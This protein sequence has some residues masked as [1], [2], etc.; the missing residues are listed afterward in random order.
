MIRRSVLKAALYKCSRSLTFNM[1][2]EYD[3][4][5]PRDKPAPEIS[6]YGFSKSSSKQYQEHND[7][8][9]EETSKIE[10]QTTSS[11]LKII[12]GLFTIIVSLSFFVAL[13]VPGGLGSYLKGAKNEPLNT[14]ARV[15]SIMSKN[16]L[17][18]YFLLSF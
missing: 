12:V 3:P 2:S 14:K 11:P 13:L 8:E 15:D 18:G 6:G 4:L 1:P 9:V 10:L 5:L 7:E 16:P 17:I